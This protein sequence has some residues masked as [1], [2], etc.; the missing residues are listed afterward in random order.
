MLKPQYSF[1]NN[2]FSFSKWQH[3]ITATIND[4]FSFLCQPLNA[5]TVKSVHLFNFQVSLKYK[6]TLVL[7]N[8]R[9][10]WR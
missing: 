5:C 4:I 2:I 8:L 3:T 1:R 6:E 10:L 9:S 7:I